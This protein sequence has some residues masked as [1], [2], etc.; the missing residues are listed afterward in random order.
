MVKRRKKDNRK[1][2]NSK[3]FKK[4][5]A[6]ARK[7]NASTVYETC[8][9]QLSPFGGLLALIKF[10]DLVNFKEIFDSAYQKPTR[11][12][13]LGD[14][15]MMV[16][17]LMLLYIGFNRIWHFAY[18]RLDAILCF[19][20]ET[21]EYLVG[22]LRKGTTVSGKETAAFILSIKEHLPGCVQSV[23]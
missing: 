18:I 1:R 21:R 13:K 14:H 7:I 17:I 8:S 10:F 6:E 12:P 2:R 16:G 4:N 22:K 5:R 20:E 15:L 3:G 11:E 19:I 9:E 23:L